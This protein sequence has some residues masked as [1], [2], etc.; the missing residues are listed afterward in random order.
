[1]RRLRKSTLIGIVMALLIGASFGAS[2]AAP[3]A[4]KA[5]MDSLV[6][7]ITKTSKL[8]GKVHVSYKGKTCSAATCTY[9][10]PA[11]T[12]ITLTQTPTDKKTWPF[13]H[14]LLNGTKKGTGPHLTFTMNGKT[15]ASAVYVFK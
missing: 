1:M 10:I 12:K 11:K 14:W 4:K 6:V 15:T 13:Q 9:S 5:K 2:F 8:W 3:A 7:K